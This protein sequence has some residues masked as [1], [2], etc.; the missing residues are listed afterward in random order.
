[1]L[2]S[3]DRHADNVDLG[4]GSSM[5]DDVEDD[6][7]TRVKFPLWEDDGDEEGGQRKG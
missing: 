4:F 2:E 1:M 5:F 7:A 6:E 3:H